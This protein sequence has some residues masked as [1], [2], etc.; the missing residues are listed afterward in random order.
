MSAT[1]FPDWVASRKASNPGR[2]ALV[3]EN[4][5]WTFA[6]LDDEVTKMARQLAG[7]G[8]AH[9]D[10]VATLLHNCAAAAIIPHA[11]LRLGA[12]LV[13]LNVRLSQA[14]IEW[15]IADASPRLVIAEHRTRSLVAKTSV[16]V[17]DLVQL[18]GADESNVELRLEHGG[19]S[20]LAIIYTS[21]TTGQPK[22]AMLTVA[23]FWW[24][25]IGSA[26]NLGTRDD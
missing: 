14:E 8:V 4:R 1:A 10:R 7:L 13:P 3:A 22:G 23:N 19:D 12:T 5:T 11:L 15:Q 17:V 2:V 9:G 16:E 25:A 18:K 21:G 6:Q 20:I 26:L 24:S